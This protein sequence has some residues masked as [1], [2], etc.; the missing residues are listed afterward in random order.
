[1]ALISSGCGSGVGVA[2]IVA[3]EIGSDVRVGA[4]VKIWVGAVGDGSDEA[5]LVPAQADRMSVVIHTITIKFIF[6]MV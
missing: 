6:F 3:V 4:G 2:T 1:M 5:E